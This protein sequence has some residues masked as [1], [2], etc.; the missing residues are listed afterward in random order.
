MRDLVFVAY[1]ALMIGLAFKRPFLMVPI[2]LYIDIVSPQRLTYVLLNSVPISAIAFLLAFGAFLLVDD[3]R[4][5]R[6]SW[7]QALIIVLLVYCFYTTQHA[8][9]PLEAKEKWDWVWKSL[10]FGIFLPFTLRTR[11]RIET[12]ILSIVLCVSSIIVTGGIKTALSGGGYGQL[13]LMVDNN[14]GLYESSIIST[15]AIAIIPLILWLARYGTII[16]PGRV[17]WAYSLAL[18]GACLLIPIGT[19]ARTGLLCI[20]LLML[21]MLYKAKRKLLYTSGIV[22]M[23]LAAIPFLPASFT[24]RMD[25]IQNYQGD[26]SA[27]TRLAVWKWTWDYVQLHPGGG[28]FDAYRSNSFTYDAVRIE[29][30]GGAS[31]V[32]RMQITDK[33]R[34]YHNSYF[35][36]LGEQGFFGLIIW[37]LIGGLTVIAT[38]RI[39]KQYVKSEAPDEQWIAPLA[40]ALQQALF[41]YLLGA[42]FVG[43]AYQP[44]YF[45]II[46]VH[47]GFATY[48]ARI[49]KGQT[50]RPIFKLP[51]RPDPAPNPV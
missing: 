48:I 6:F 43:I 44:V 30:E 18:I 12:I 16:K 33:G 38:H 10:I 9:F 19:E 27:S 46:G 22:L 25:T 35:E 15:V 24:Q 23:G 50:V 49:R 5:S 41:I 45:M 4:D 14:T 21:M 8:D 31:K 7:R 13:N 39:Y 2:Y 32:V 34:A 40:W 51:P 29:K 1:L 37:L 47:I 28:G 20:A 42:F 11:L 3:K 36:V 17:M 26:Q